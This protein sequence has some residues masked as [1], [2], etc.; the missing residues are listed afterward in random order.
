[1]IS[2]A[3][4]NHLDTNAG[5][6]AVCKSV[7]PHRIPDGAGVPALVYRM[8]FDERDNLLNGEGALR[9]ALYAVDCYA[10]KYADAH[11]IATAVEAAMIGFRGTFGA[12]SPSIDVDH[13]RLERKIDLFETDT[14]YYRVSLQFL[15]AYT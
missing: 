14:G 3:L 15:I 5:I 1:M 7:F 13:V 6:N 12:T 9:Q 2:A 10:D 8:D 4:F 11:T